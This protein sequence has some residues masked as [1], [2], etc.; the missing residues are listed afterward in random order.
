MPVRTLCTVLAMSFAVAATLAGCGDEIAPASD[1]GSTDAG[2]TGDT[3]DTSDVGLDSRDEPDA[4]VDLGS[5]ADGGADASED[6]DAG[7]FSDVTL[8]LTECLAGGSTTITNAEGGVISFEVAERVTVAA[9]FPPNAVA[10]DTAATFACTDDD[11][12]PEGFIAL[13]GSVEVTFAGTLSR[14][15][16]LRV[17]FRPSD[18][19]AGARSSAIRLFFAPA[20][21]APVTSPP[22]VDL[23]ENLGRGFATFGTRHAGVYQV[24]IAEDAGETYEREWQFRA[25]TGVSMG[26]SGAS[27]IGMR[28]P[29]AFDI[30]GALGGP[31]SWTY[32]SHYIEVG[33][34]GGFALAGEEGP[35]EMFTPTEELEHA[36]AFDNFWFPTGDGTGGTFDRREY[37]RIFQDLALS[38]GNLSG[39]SEESPF[40]PAGLDPAELARPASERCPGGEGTTTIA[41]GFYDDEYNPT[42]SLPVIMF[43]DGVG[44]RDRSIPFDRACDINEDGV[45]DETNEGLYPGPEGQ[46]LPV[47]IAWAVDLDGDGLRDPGEPVIRNFH[48][49]FEDVGGD[50]LASEDEDG[51][52]PETNPDPAGDDY[53]YYAN[54][55]G[56]EGNWLWDEGEPFDDLGLDGVA[57]TPQLDEGGYDWGEGNET[58]DYNPHL[59]ALLAE[60]DPQQLARTLDQDDWDALTVYIDAGVR[61]LFNFGVSGNHFAG[62]IAAAGQNL[63]IYDGFFSLANLDPELDDYRFAEV[64]YGSLGDHVYLRY[65]SLDASEEDVCYGDGKHVGTVPQIANRL[66]TLLGLIT[67]RFPE[68]DLTRLEAPYPTPSGNYLFRSEAFGGTEQ[69]SII[70]PPGYEWRAC[71]DNEDNDGDGLSDGDD[72]GCEHG[73]DNSE[74]DGLGPALCSDGIDNDD[75]GLTDFPEDTDCANAE[76]GSEWPA[77]HPLRDA[78]FP[79]VYLLHGYGQTPDD[80]RAAVIPFAGFMAGGIWQKAI[81]V[82]PDGYCGDNE[83]LACNDGVDNDEDG[84]I[85]GDDEDCAASG[86]RSED[87]S[88]PPR[89]SDG[90]DND[91]DGRVD[92]E[93]GGCVSPE[94]DDESDCVKGNFYTNHIAWPDGST[95]GPPF[96]D[97]M[98]ELIDH[99]DA[100]YR[101]RGPETTTERR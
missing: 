92:D 25:I 86:G 13:S 80:L 89:C 14:Y 5:D 19:P 7:G 15:A 40:L 48:E 28:N 76:D 34:M 70:L 90:V 49:P 71:N 51:Y 45:P 31:T 41:T 23:Q 87:G 10:E 84:D 2:D 62:S 11:I 98:F 37:I 81:V 99:V 96:E 56:A 85:D 16:T 8:D 68:G 97:M 72:P 93:D 58:F 38:F 83:V 82:Y 67:N 100:T 75:D 63:R 73:M 33:G 39:Y 78:R 17:P 35:G 91:R 27:M 54:P 60:R 42:G 30:I 26:C 3:G 12:V 69:Y 50:G 74:E 4:T 46:N 55:N 59:A 101:T 95:P 29:E 6:A 20:S 52:D 57:E 53:D 94:A 1:T 88:T 21:G 36:Q 66:L 32:L 77:G 43:C 24:A 65:G 18:M 47:V 79:V 9:T 64:D 61:D 22:A 44:S